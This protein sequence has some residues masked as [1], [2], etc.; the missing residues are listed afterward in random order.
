MIDQERKIG[1]QHLRYRIM[2]GKNQDSFY[3]FNDISDDVTLLYLMDLVGNVNQA[4]SIVGKWISDSNFRRYLPLWV[5]SLNLMCS[6][7]DGK[8]VFTLFKKV[9][10]AVRYINTKAKIKKRHKVLIPLHGGGMYKKKKL[11]NE[12]KKTDN[13]EYLLLRN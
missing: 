12:H 11:Y 5:E 4:V 1:E 2:K 10:Y 8:K 9:F 7:S 3:A 6:S 13:E